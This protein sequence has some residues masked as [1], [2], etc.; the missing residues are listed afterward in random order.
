GLGRRGRRFR[1]VEASHD[2]SCQT[3]FSA[4]RLQTPSDES[5]RKVATW[6]AHEKKYHGRFQRLVRSVGQAPQMPWELLY[7]SGLDWAP[8]PLLRWLGTPLARFLIQ[9]VTTYN[10]RLYT[11][12]RLDRHMCKDLLH[13]V[14]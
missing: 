11:G 5:E 12:H 4:A 13:R 10:Q 14:T 7:E 6:C 3:P 9:R 8:L 2:G 1:L